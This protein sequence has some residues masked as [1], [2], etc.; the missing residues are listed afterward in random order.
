MKQYGHTQRSLSPFEGVETGGQRLVLKRL[1]SG[2]LAGI[3]FVSLERG[4]N[5]GWRITSQALRGT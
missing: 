2:R 4:V 5:V 1:F 3:F